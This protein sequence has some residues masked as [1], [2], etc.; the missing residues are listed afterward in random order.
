AGA[1]GPVRQVVNWSS[2]PFWPQGLDRPN[3]AEPVP[4]G[5]D[6]DLWLGPAPERPFHH[7]YLPFVWRGWYDFGCGALGAMGAY[8]FDPI[9][10]ALRWEARAS[11]EASSPERPAES[12]PQAGLVHFHSPARGDLPRVKLTWYDGGLKPPR[13]EDLEPDRPLP[14]EGLL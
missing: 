1:V 7:A 14:E 11:V 8:R 2:R 12:S 10:R 3:Q 6:W 13:P 5:L 9:F 4:A